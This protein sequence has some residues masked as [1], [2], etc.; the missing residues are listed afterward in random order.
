MLLTNVIIIS[1]G[2]LLSGLI[3]TRVFLM[4]SKLGLSNALS[5]QHE[6]IRRPY[7]SG[8][9]HILSVSPS[10]AM[11]RSGSVRRF[12]RYVTFHFNKPNILIYNIILL[13]ILTKMDMFK[14]SGDIICSRYNLLVDAISF[15]HERPLKRY[16]IVEIKHI[17]T[18]W[19]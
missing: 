16:N 9:G 3:L 10:R 6:S 8:H 19:V 12:P 4:V 7:R 2:F 5:A 1:T 13:S 11:V 18:Y 15:D 17:Y 14:V